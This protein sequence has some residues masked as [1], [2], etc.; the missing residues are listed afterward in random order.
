MANIKTAI[1]ELHKAFHKLNKE[2]FNGE[3][4]E[5]AILIQ[6]QGNRKN[7][8]GWCSV[9]EIWVDSEKKK[10]HEI[11]ICA[12]HLN[13]HMLAV[14]STLLHE[15]VHL[16]NLTNGI[17][18]VS[19]NGTYHNKNFKKQGEIRG[20]IVEHDPN[21]GWSITKIHPSLVKQIYTY[22]IDESAFSLARMSEK[23]DK[24]KSSL[25]KYVCPECNTSIK[26]T[27]EVN[28][29]CGDCNCH[30]ELVEEEENDE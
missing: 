7:V 17:T 23:K 28:I 25:R 30:Y 18:D 11:N 29:I 2:L 19:R 16:Y 15:M 9:A 12:E 5:P 22:G 1:N 24:K 14:L 20:L 6:N 27:K 3:L 8:L 4:P 10:R 26:A 21:L 13:R